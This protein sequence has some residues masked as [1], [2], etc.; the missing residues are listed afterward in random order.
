MPIVKHDVF[1]QQ[2][3]VFTGDELARHL[4]RVGSDGMRTPERVLGYR[5]RAGRLRRIRQ[6]MYAVIP[7]GA[8]GDTYPVDPYLVA[9]KLTPDAVL[10]HH[11]ALEFHG[12]AYSVWQ[13]FTYSAERPV[14]TLIFRDQV[15]RGAKFPQAL[16]R[17]G[18][19]YRGVLAV[20]RFGVPV[21]VTSLERTLVDVL[22]RPDLAGGWEEVWRSLEGVEFFNLDHVVAYTLLLGNATT[23][24]RVGFFL[25]QHQEILM[26]EDGHLKAL[27]QRCP[28]QPHYL[29]RSRRRGGKLAAEWNLVVPEEV[30][31]R[32]WEEVG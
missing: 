2:H 19:E 8:D 22:H 6:G 28:R 16:L 1:F 14:E 15:F 4:A 18:E 32:S 31:T 21:R 12:R 17:S 13:H 9:A 7:P 25:E 26:V 20:E 24:A 30:L 11:T 10:S 5:T 3:P 27:K 23:V 29:D